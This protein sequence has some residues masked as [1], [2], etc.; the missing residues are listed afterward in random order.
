[1]STDLTPIGN[2]D[3]AKQLGL[4]KPGDEFSAKITKTGK[5]VFKQRT[6]NGRNKKTAVVNKKRTVLYQSLPNK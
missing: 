6:N 4:E 5:Q 2:P 3:L 1:M